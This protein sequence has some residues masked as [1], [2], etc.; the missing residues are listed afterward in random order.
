M[1]HIHD[2]IDFCVDVF[3]VHN[4]KVLLRKHDKYKIWLGVGG[5]VELDEDPNQAAIREV[6]EEVGL[7]V[8]LVNTSKLLML[9]EGTHKTL[10]PPVFL[11]RHDINE[12]HEHISFV[13]F[14]KSKTDKFVMPTDTH[15]ISEECRWFGKEE[16]DD[17]KFNLTKH[18]VL[19][20][21]AALDMVV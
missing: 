8:E 5:H 17:K 3:I 19:Y 11:N 18:V 15:E 16:L 20:A 9:K 4:K 6:K 21:K 13:Y 12:K 14:A 1:P 7:D 10:I 2:K